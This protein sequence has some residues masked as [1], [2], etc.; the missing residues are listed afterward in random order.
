M[1]KYC[2]CAIVALAV[3]S[4]ASTQLNYNTLDIASASVDLITSQVLT[5]LGRFRSSPFAIPSQVSV[6]SG[7][8]TTTNSLTPTFS[9]PFGAAVT[10]T[11]ANSAAAP[12]FNA[13]THTH[14]TPNGTTGLTA[15][16]Q[17]SQNW[18]VTPLEDPDQLRR[19]QALYRFGAGLTDAE[20]LA[21]E[22]PLVQ[23]AQ[24][25]GGSPP[26]SQSNQVNVSVNGANVSVNGANT[27]TGEGNNASKN[28][29]Y[30]YSDDVDKACGWPIRK[31]APVGTPDPAF[32]KLPGCVIC[33]VDASKKTDT[34]GDGDGDMKADASGAGVKHTFYGKLDNNNIVT[35]I[36]Q[37]LTLDFVGTPISGICIPASTTIISVDDKNIIHIS[38]RPNCTAP[39][40]EIT[41]TLPKPPK[42]P[43]QPQTHTLVVNDRLS[44]EWLWSP[45]D[46]EPIPSG[47]SLL[48]HYGGQDLYL[49][50][51]LEMSQ[52]EYSDFVLFVL[53]ATLQSTS[54]SGGASGKGAPQKGGSPQV[55]QQPAASELMLQ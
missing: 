7:S 51:P 38:A 32:L 3:A 29:N 13:T 4:C 22:Y 24:G 46:G 40:E 23:K 43:S 52:K 18:T 27:S 12:L 5:N 26:A 19:L 17:W 14:L 9:V 37:P 1:F 54:A 33:D 42:S 41:A 34:D 6:P 45:V 30:T 36:G 10:T 11:L 20:H 21:C 53:E 15:A 48:G 8:A 49:N 16:D 55:V 50:P 47:A 25:S 44:N 31:P 39:K 35:V 2:F 28:V